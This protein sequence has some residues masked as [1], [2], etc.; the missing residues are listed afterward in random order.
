M[1]G[2]TGGVVLLT[3]SKE[4]WGVGV[5]WCSCGFGFF[6]KC[7]GV[8]RGGGPVRCKPEQESSGRKVGRKERRKG[9]RIIDLPHADSSGQEEKGGLE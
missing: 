6:V 2:L 8:G 9:N 1:W 4:S 7:A 3:L 5:V